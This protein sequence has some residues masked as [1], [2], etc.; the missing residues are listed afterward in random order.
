MGDEYFGWAAE[1]NDI[2]PLI[3]DGLQEDQKKIKLIRERVRSMKIVR[4]TD[5]VL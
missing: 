5:E 4:P 3:S 2:A 1:G